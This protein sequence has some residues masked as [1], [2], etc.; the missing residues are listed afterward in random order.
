ML[1]ARVGL[2]SRWKPPTEGAA[3]G[4]KR[5]M[6]QPHKACGGLGMLTSLELVQLLKVFFVFL[7]FVF[8]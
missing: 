3:E 7:F 1:R 6:R 2:E 5:S 8:S 4:I